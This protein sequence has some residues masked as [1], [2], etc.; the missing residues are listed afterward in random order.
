ML[1]GR[2][3]LFLFFQAIIALITRS[4]ESSEKYWLLTA[5]LTNLVSL[6]TFFGYIM[7]NLQKQLNT[8]WLSL[9]H[10]ALPLIPDLGLILY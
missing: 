6:A 10:C 7:P 3:I 9:Q 5:T 8:K 2:L 1:P 4:W